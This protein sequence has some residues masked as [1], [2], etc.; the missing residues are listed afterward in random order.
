MLTC[1]N[2]Y[3]IFITVPF[4]VVQITDKNKLFQ[5]GSVFYKPAKLTCALYK[6]RVIFTVDGRI[7][8]IYLIS[9]SANDLAFTD[10]MSESFF[11]LSGI[12]ASYDGM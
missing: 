8:L 3:T 4:Q 5:S 2:N 9:L 6:H 10:M 1:P 7:T 11:W 12:S